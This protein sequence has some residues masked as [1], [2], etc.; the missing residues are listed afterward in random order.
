[1]KKSTVFLAIAIGLAICWSLI[2][3]VM[4]ASTL[5]SYM[6]GK[7]SSYARSDREYLESKKKTFPT[8][9]NEL[10]ISGEGTLDLKI[11]PGKELTVLAHPKVWN[12]NYID[13]KNGKAIIRFNI[14]QKYPNS[15]TIRLPEIPVISFDNFYSVNME[16]LNYR[17]IRIQGNRITYF[18]AGNCKIGSLNLDFPGKNDQQEIIISKSN[19]IDTLIASVQGFGNIRLETAG[20]LNNQISISESM[21][22][23]ASYDLM[24][25][26]ALK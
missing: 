24:K 2:I 26:L 9:I 23:E 3:G 4:A 10:F 12:S 6:K 1:M 19:Q 22:L 21:K 14:I 11:V 18:T 25:K 20:K 5:N 17:E 15:V 13:L 16:G 8:P 7:S